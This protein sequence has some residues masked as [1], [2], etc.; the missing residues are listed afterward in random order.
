MRE[1]NKPKIIQADNISLSYDKKT[2]V[3]NSSTFCIYSNDFVVVTGKSGSGKSTLLNSLYGALKISSGSLSVCN[4]DLKS[5][6]SKKMNKLRKNLGVIFQDYRLIDE[7][8]INKNIMLPLKINGYS[9]SVCDN[10]A[11]KL[12]Q[13]VKLA[14]KGNVY[15]RELSGGEQQRVAVARA[16]AH[17]P[18]LILADEPT[19]NLDEYSSEVVWN[20]LKNVNEQLGITVVVV[21]HTI[22]KHIELLYKH[23]H[24]E[25]GYIREII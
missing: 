19:G 15:P 16:L 20:L 24:I 7:W 10:Q 23:L 3:I 1:L 13:H 17:N 18:L 8:N 12:L 22:P 25:N 21:T 2:N 11:Q 14:N 9:Q 5:A 4:I 6:N